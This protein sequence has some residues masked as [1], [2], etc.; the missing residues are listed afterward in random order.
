M[1]KVIAEQYIK[2]GITKMV[3]KYSQGEKRNKHFM[4]WK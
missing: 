1:I 4:A 2:A 3:E